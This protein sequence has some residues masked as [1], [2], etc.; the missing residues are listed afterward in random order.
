MVTE[1][2]HRTDRKEWNFDLVLGKIE[3]RK[4]DIEF[5][6]NKKKTNP[7][8]RFDGGGMMVMVVALFKTTEKIII[9]I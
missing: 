5:F 7:C 9:Y 2:N 4:R 3:N 1:K 6:L 8:K